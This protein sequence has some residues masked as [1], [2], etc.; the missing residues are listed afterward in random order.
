MSH[1]NPDDRRKYQ[2]EYY[3]SIEQKTRRARVQREYWKRQRARIFTRDA[4]CCV[5]CRRKFAE[6]QLHVDHK[7]ALAL[8][9][10]NTDSNRVT[11]C[12]WCNRV[13]GGK[14]ICAQCLTWASPER[15]DEKTIR[16]VRC[17]AINSFPEGTEAVDPEAEPEWVSG[18]ESSDDDGELGA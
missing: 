18:E 13:K 11:S 7:V 8:G 6:K 2:R 12:R 9:G 1:R 5:Y 14:P 4:F 3:K 10:R 16:C 15:I 17:R